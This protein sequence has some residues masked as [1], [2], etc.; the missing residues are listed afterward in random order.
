MVFSSSVFLFVF[1]PIL[2]I[3]YFLIPTT[4]LKNAVLFIASVIF[5]AWGEPVHI[6][7]MLG[8]IVINY[9]FGR[10]MEGKPWIRKTSFAC[11]IIWN[12]GLLFAFKYSSF[13][14]VSI[15]TIFK[16][17]IPVP[18]IALPIGISFYTFQILSYIIDVYRGEYKAQR[19]ILYLG[20]YVSLFPQLI[21]GPIVRYAQIEGQL[22]IRKTDFNNIY[23][24][25]KR[26][27]IGFSK[28]I[29]IADQ[30]SPLVDSIVSGKYPSILAYWMGA[31]AYTL[32]IYYDFCGY[33]DMAI[34]LGKVFGF[35]FPENFN[36]PYFS[37]SISEFWR[38]WHITLGSWFKDYVYIPLGGNRKGIRKTCVN[39]FV[40]FL[41]T[42]MWHGAGLNYLI[43]GI[44]YAV[45]IIAEKLLLKEKLERFPVWIGRVYTLIVVIV[46]WVIF[47]V[48][49][50]SNLCMYLRGMI[51]P[52]GKDIAYM[53]M[54]MNPL[55]YSVM[56]VGVFLSIPHTR[57]MGIM[58]HG[59]IT[60]WIKDVVLIMLF[61]VA[62]CFMHGSGFSPFL[63]YRF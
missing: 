12:I 61:A 11:A 32:Q 8:S 58:N 46:G 10:F 33:S 30:L 63:Y 44:Y 50:M 21:A 27:T 45:F 29:L 2:L 1:L 23:L 34:G 47:R 40:V 5:Y 16:M 7:L 18:N 39:L 36:H 22:K 4:S 57:L 31:V 38:R 55:Y 43:W 35:E 37:A 54:A 48:D 53:Q 52:S 20:M 14:V 28:K 56:G 15:N 42:G 49:S 60:K 51:F 59:T 17:N 13:F 24:G 41:L 26:F 9:F 3:V 25:L 6:F 19:N 62:I